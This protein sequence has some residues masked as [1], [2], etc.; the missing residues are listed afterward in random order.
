MYEKNNKGYKSIKILFTTP[1][2]TPTIILKT[3]T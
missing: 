2:Y 3:Y 1:I